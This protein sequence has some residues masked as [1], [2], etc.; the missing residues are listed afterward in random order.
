MP[1]RMLSVISLFLLGAATVDAGNA[2]TPSVAMTNAVWQV[3]PRD[4]I[5]SR[6]SIS[7]GPT[8]RRKRALLRRSTRSESYLPADTLSVRKKAGPPPVDST[9]RLEQFLHDRK[10]VASA[11]ERYRTEHHLYLRDPASVRLES[12]LDST[13]W[14]YTVR[15]LLGAMDLRAPVILPFE[16]YTRLRLDYALRTTWAQMVEATG[17]QAAKKE[18]LGELFGKVTN[19][20][21]PVPKNP[22]FSIF[23]PNIIR[24][25]INGAVN[26]HAA[27]RNTK[28]DQFVASPLGQ[29]RNEPDFNQEVQVTLKGEIG[30]KLKINADWNT[31]R[32]FEYENQLKV[33]YTGY[34]DEMVQYVEAGNVSL[35]TSSAFIPPS[36]ALFGIKAGFQLGPLRLTTVAS[37]KK[38][39]I[40]ELSVSGGARPT[41]FERKV[42]DYS[43]DHFFIDIAYIPVYER[44]FN[45]IPAE[46]DPSL[47]IQEME[48]WVTSQATFDAK[49]RNVVAFMSLDSV[50]T[51][52][53]DDAARF[54]EYDDIPGEVQVGRFTQLTEGS[55]FTFDPNAGIISI[56]KPLQADQAVAVAYRLQLGGIAAQL[57][58]FGARDTSTAKK[59][60][61]KLVRPKNLQPQ[62]RTAWKLMLKN[63]YPLGGRGIKKDGFEFKIEYRVS[64]PWLQDVLPQNVNLLELFGLD[65]YLADG[66]SG[67]DKTFDFIS[68]TTIDEQRGEIIFPFVEPF[69]GSTIE[70]VLLARQFS[71]ADAKA[72]ADSFSFNA[73]YDT[74]YNG[75]LNDPRNQVYQFVG[76]ITPSTASTYSLGFNIVEGS[77]EV[78]VDGQRTTA[79]VDYTVDYI[80]GIVTIKNQ[81]LL[82][83]GRNLQIRYEANDL[84]QLASKSLIGARGEV[85]LGS[86]SSLGFT[87]MNLN[88]Q[89]LSDKV[90]I[91]EE[92]TSNTI[93]GFDGQAQLDVP[94]VTKALNWLPGVRTIAPSAVSVRGEAAYISP[95]PNTR[96]SSIPQDGGSGIA[97][98]DDFEGARRTIPL[99]VAYTAW[100]DA[101]PPFYVPGLD[102]A[103]FPPGGDT[104]ISNT[105]AGLLPDSTR[106]Q[107]K[108]KLIWFNVL[109]S[110]VFVQDIWGDR[111]SVARGQEQVSVLNLYYQPTERGMYNYSMNL[112]GTLQ[113][114]PTRSWAGIQRTLGSTA[115][116]LL[117]ENINFIEMWVNIYEAGPGATLRIN[118]GYISEEIIPNRE[119][120]TEDGLDGGIINGILNPGVEDIGI[121]RL[122]DAEERTRY[123]DFVSKYPQYNGDPAGDN[124]GSPPLGFAEALSG[125]VGK[126]FGPAN[127]TENSAGSEL[128]RRFPDTEDLNGNNIVDRVNGYF[129]YEIPLD[130][131]SPGFRNY[132]VGGGLNGW[133]QVRLPL[134]EVRR[135]IGTASF[136][137][138]ESVR[139]W[140]GGA[141]SDVL[142]RIAEMNLVGNQWEEVRRND[143]TFKVSTVNFEDNP[144]YSIPPG[145]QRER[146]R[147]RPDEEVYG[148]EQ[149]LN[150]VLNGIN[151]GENRQ[152]V[153]RY[154][155]RPLDLFNYRAMKMFIHGEE[156]LGQTFRY[157]DSTNY[158]AEVFIRFGTDSLSYYEYRAPI[159]P[160]WDPLNDVTIRFADLSAIKL[161]RDS[162]GAPTARVPVPDG[163][164]GATYQI[165]GEPT[166]N[167]VTT[168]FIGVENPAGV[169]AAQLHG[170]VWVNE[171]RLTDVDDTP[172][173]AYRMETSIK[174]AD[175]A[176]VQFSMQRRDPFFHGIEERFGTRL[177]RSDWNLSANIGLEKFLPESWQGTQLSVSYSHVESM[178]RPRYLPGTDV[179]VDEAADRIDTDTS[180]TRKKLAPTGK[181]LLVQ[182]QDLAVTETYAV[183]AVRLAIPV[184]SWLVTETVNRMT[185]GFSYTASVRRSPTV[186]TSSA[187]SWN[188]RFGYSLPLSPDAFVVPFSSF[189][190]TFL[191]SVWKQTKV[192]YAPRQ[193]SVTAALTR[194]QNRNQARNQ[195]Q[196]N[197]VNRT[198]GAQ[199]SIQLNWPLIEGGLL[200]P[201][202]DYQADI[203]SNMSHLELDRFGQQ[204]S[205]ADIL[206]DA[207]FGEKP[208]S[209]GFDTQYGQTMSFTTRPVLPS[210][211]MLNRIFVPS[212]RYSSRY[213]WNRNLQAGDLGRTAGWNASLTMGLDINLQMIGDQIW[214]PETA[215]PAPAPTDTV[216]RGRNP[217]AALGA[218]SRLLL[219]TAIFDFERLSMTFTQ[220]NTSQ[221]NGVLGRPGFANLFARVPFV[222]SSLTENGPSLLYQLG[223][224]SDPHGDVIFGT[225]GSFPFVRGRTVRGP[226]APIGNLT[227]VF[228]QSNKIAL[229]TSRRLWEG[230]TLDLNW[231][232]SWSFNRNETVRTD[233]LGIPTVQARTVSGDVDRT[234]FTLPPVLIFKLFKTGVVDVNTRFERLRVDRGDTRPDEVKISQAFE[235]G[236][237]A[238]PV[239]AQILGSFAP[240]ANWS[241]RWDG[242]EKFVLF[243]SWA[244]KVN[245]DHVYQ[246]NFRRRWRLSPDGQEVADGQT[247]MY[248]FAPLA[249]VNINFKEV[250]KGNLSAQFRYGTTTSFD[251]T[252][253][254][255]SISESSTEDISVSASYSRQG[256]EFPLF[257]LS[258]SNDLMTTLSY[259]YSRNGRKLYNLKENFKPEGQPLDGSNRTTI[260]P[261]I[262]YILSA[263]VTASLY[264]RYSK[265]APD[266]GGSKITGNTINEGGL[267]VQIS[268]Q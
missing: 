266:A 71:P 128:G 253:S 169:G 185:F 66:T 262:R 45:Q 257:G 22:L 130:T 210:V 252:P 248:A 40:K 174:L 143:P 123:A 107:H 26:I 67:R 147:T 23:G 251:L 197:P 58:N 224:S 206:Q 188:A 15:Y 68:R 54:R 234:F 64:G 100:R 72:Y 36:A 92:P 127:G 7:A 154:A 203:S 214:G 86:K 11:A 184:R 10:D 243:K 160:G 136:T 229:R 155:I 265:V 256:F 133:Y 42:V 189:G 192:Y 204:R 142:V 116:N 241:F 140:V 62:F 254:V 170:E 202:I 84:F 221:N 3:A 137:N 181:E 176:S 120:D 205:L 5:T 144:A 32:T 249:G 258:L 230:A 29:S 215:M 152:A 244:S 261:R 118:L 57:G 24:L 232:V 53:T 43:R 98:I 109:P 83:P 104:L 161:V 89:S 13:E 28:S 95:D 6:A 166:L 268:I 223:L 9:A 219:K 134:N 227:D 131:A 16:E 240:R 179:L 132:V 177:D 163:P 112:E 106:F 105:L 194:A 81:T 76:T 264:Y 19:I 173:W 233:S 12:K 207:L 208:L 151:D 237:E 138:I 60:V 8:N 126:R 73:I 211:L 159:R 209:F 114:L 47:Q 235:E 75:A 171:L 111:R 246:S 149:S 217:L 239:L 121:D 113:A 238:L 119:L 1:V 2:A 69:R 228:S 158:D 115:S 46:P 220:V 267:D 108:A 33:R 164:P 88:Q 182:S 91:G 226:R 255:L 39:Q 124:W 30:D 190:E 212:L 153:K 180:T 70:R 145:V 17:F 157:I 61:M 187:W 172:G 21:I 198:F 250:L 78:I 85:D 186:R 225:T 93:L 178:S 222:Q 213:D 74:T 27:F 175:I 87:I 150:L 41:P 37:Q 49:D 129:E 52:Q 195:T 44:I 14:I 80:T 102:P 31:Q 59:L 90:R 260:E 101:S 82:V 56:N 103:L 162:A 263:R 242:L 216:P 122:R 20:E 259:T 193:I 135:K 99:G 218:V 35:P 50:R 96:K 18:G 139:L 148:N 97:Y 55:D 125:S 191:L 79:N 247:I 63:R 168:I 245:V 183:P 77:V 201:Q 48:V 146:D 4:S 167:R 25:Q 236:M 231:N 141:T 94:F 38:G 110:D 199:R 117:D 65:R 200:S 165:R 51:K 34:E 196:E 156:R